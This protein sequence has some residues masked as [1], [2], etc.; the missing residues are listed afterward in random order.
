MSS[1]NGHP[2]AFMPEVTADLRGVPTAECVCGSRTFFAVMWLD[3]DYDV[4]GYA[5]D[6]LCPDCGALVTLATA[7][8]KPGFY[9]LRDVEGRPE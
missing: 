1:S 9:D 2:F 5:T 7:I 4:A 6:G 3:D 8:D